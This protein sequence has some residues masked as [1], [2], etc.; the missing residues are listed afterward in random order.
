MWPTYI[1]KDAKKYT[2]TQIIQLSR[3][4][5]NTDNEKEKHLVMTELPLG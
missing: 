1:K 2:D 5:F 3:Y 4:R